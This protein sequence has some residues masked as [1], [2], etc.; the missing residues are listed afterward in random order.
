MDP[1]PTV[2]IPIGAANLHQVVNWLID[3]INLQ[4][5]NLAV[6]PADQVL[7]EAYTGMVTIRLAP[8]PEPEPEPEMETPAV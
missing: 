8:A 2:T 1:I 4:F 3:Q 6:P 7:P 5:A